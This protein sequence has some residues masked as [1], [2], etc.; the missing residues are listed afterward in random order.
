MYHV[1]DADSARARAVTI[2]CELVVPDL[3]HAAPAGAQ[4]H[5]EFRLPGL[6]ALLAR[7]RITW[8]DG[9]SLER[10]LALR[11]G[12][13]PG[14]DLPLA[15]LALL[16]EGLPP[17]DECWLHAD[18]VHLSVRRDELMLTDAGMAGI[19]EAEAAQFTRALGAHFGED[20]L[21]FVAPRP[22]RWYVRVRDAPR[23]RTTPTAEVMGRRIEP[24]LPQGDDGP[25]WRRILNETQMLLHDHPC[26]TERESR[27]DPPVNSVWYWGAGRL[28]ALAPE[29]HYGAI[30]SAQALAAGI[31]KATNVPLHALPRSAAALAGGTAGARPQLIVLDALRAVLGQ[32]VDAWR[33]ALME[34]ETHW[35]APLLSALKR[36]ELT[37]VTVHALGSARSCAVTA[38]RL[39][40]LRFW[41]GKRALGEYAAEPA[42]SA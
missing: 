39:A 41:R 29:S 13:A 35:F 14:P 40:A 20:G 37:T 26:N 6:E 36:G 12:I 25:K 2:A 38:T 4:L 9:M 42:T 7:G 30:W 33:A 23:V 3:L 8:M 10:W 24:L 27:G 11:F 18:P 16:G 15:A 5:A 21:G 22:H 31:A 32:G 34:L 19:T 1:A 17:G 28:P